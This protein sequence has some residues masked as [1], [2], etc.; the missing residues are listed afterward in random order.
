MG[1]AAFTRLMLVLLLTICGCLLLLDVQRQRDL[2]AVRSEV[3]NLHGR[4][5]AAGWIDR[6]DVRPVSPLGPVLDADSDGHLDTIARE[7]TAT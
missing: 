6:L 2:R 1:E 5:N 4:L 7:R 3:D